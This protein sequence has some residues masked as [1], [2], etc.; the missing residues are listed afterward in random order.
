MK[1]FAQGIINFKRKGSET[2]GKIF[3]KFKGLK[4]K[5]NPEKIENI[6]SY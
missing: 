6:P 3:N 5:V 4:N 1:N 2:F